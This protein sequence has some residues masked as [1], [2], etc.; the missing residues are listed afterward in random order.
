[1]YKVEVLADLSEWRDNGMRFATRELA[2]DYARDLY[3]RWA[4][5]HYWR[6]VEEGGSCADDT[7]A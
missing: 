2:E 5:V 1:M 4:A 6:V 3:M 7:K